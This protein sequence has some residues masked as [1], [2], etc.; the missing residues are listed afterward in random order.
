MHHSRILSKGFGRQRQDRIAKFEQDKEKDKKKQ[1]IYFAL[2][3]ILLNFT[4]P[5]QLEKFLLIVLDFVYCPHLAAQLNNAY[6]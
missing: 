1:Y 3:S 6:P 5:A 2:L 4:W